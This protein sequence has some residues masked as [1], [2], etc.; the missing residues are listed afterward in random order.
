MNPTDFSGAGS[1]KEHVDA[2]A[3]G[4]LAAC[5]SQALP[6]VVLTIFVP[7]EFP[8]VRHARGLDQLQAALQHN[9]DAVDNQRPA[10]ADVFAEGNT[11]VMFGRE[12]G[13]I[14]GTG[15]QYDV[16]FVEKF[17]FKEGRLAEVR[18][19]AAHVAPVGA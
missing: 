13:T 8:F 12:T 7:P 14:R 9:F 5:L 11:V 4:D 18:I 1:L 19:I 3:R 15:T 16:E 6:D 10:I 17:T 2:I